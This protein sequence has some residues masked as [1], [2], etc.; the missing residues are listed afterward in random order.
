MF[1]RGPYMSNLLKSLVLPEVEKELGLQVMAQKIRLNLLPFYVEALE[2][3]VFDESGEKIIAAASIKAYMSIF[4][5]LERRLIPT[6]IVIKKPKVWLDR[7]KAAALIGSVGGPENKEAKAAELNLK[8]IVVREGE[9]YYRDEGLKGTFEARGLNAEVILRDRP[10]VVMSVG[11]L[12]AAV[13]DWPEMKGSL[14]ANFFV[15]KEGVEIK[16]I[17]VDMR[18]STLSGS[19]DYF[20]N[21][22]GVLRLDINVL[23]ETIKELRRLNKPGYG[24]IRARGTLTLTEDLH[25][26]LLDFSVKGDF[27]LQTLLEA[28]KA[29]TSHELTGLVSFDGDLFGSV[30]ELKGRADARLRDGNLYTIDVD[31]IRCKVSY[32]DRWLR[33]SEGKAELY[34]G[35]GEL[36]VSFLLPRAKP[37]TVEADFR[38]VDSRSAFGKIGLGWMNLPAGKVRG[39]L[40][41]SGMEFAPEGWASYESGGRREDPIGRVSTITGK[42]RMKNHVVTLVDME[43]TSAA[44]RLT[45]GG[46]LNTASHIIDLEGDLYTDDVMELTTPYFDKLRG[47]AEFHGGVSGRTGDPMVEG[48]FLIHDSAL[49]DYPLGEVAAEASYRKNLLRVERANAESGESVYK[50]A[51]TVKFPEATG[52]L[53]LSKPDFDLEL[54]VRKADLGDILGMLD[55]EIPIE[56]DID[57]KVNIKGIGR[58][59]YSGDVEIADGMVWD[60]PLSSASLSFS[61]DYKAA[62]IRNAELRSGKSMLLLDGRVAEGGEFSF[63]AS[64]KGLYLKDALPRPLPLNYRVALNAE[65]SGTFDNPKIDLSSTLS[66]GT[67]GEWPVGGG[68]VDATLTGKDLA[69]DAKLLDDKASAKGG[70]SIAGDMPW[71]AEVEVEGARLDFLATKFLKEIPEDLLLSITGRASMSGTK[72]HVSANVAVRQVTMAM[73]GQSFTNDSDILFTADDTFIKFPDFKL[74]SGTT[75]VSFQGE[76]RYGDYYDIMVYGASSL[77][78]LK[79]FSD[80]I[81]L[82]R[83]NANYVLAVQGPWQKPNVNGGIDIKGG[84]FGIQGIPQRLAEVNGYSYFEDDVVVIDNLEAKLGGGDIEVKGVMT[85]EGLSPKSVNLDMLLD[86]VNVT[87]TTGLKA[88][89]GGSIIF[90][91]LPAERLLTGEITINRAEYKDRI[92][93]KSWLLKVRQTEA[94][95]IARKGPFDEVKLSLKLYG[96]EDIVIDNNLATAEL[97]MDL[98]LRGTVGQPLLL[99]RIE[100]NE[101]K[102]YFRNSVFR[103]AHATAD[104]SDSIYTDPYVDIVSETTVKGYHVWLTLEGKLDHLDMTLLSDPELED[105]EILSLLTVG[106]FGESLRGLEGSIGAAEASS[107]IA[108]K[109]QDLVEERFR[110]LTGVTRFTIEPYVSRKTGAITPRVSVSKGL[111][112]EDLYVTYSSSIST[113]EEQEIVLEYVINRNV[114][115][116]GGQDDLGTLGGDIKFR[117]LFK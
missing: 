3:K 71:N 31:D 79:A 40:Y 106:E 86:D 44:S 97:E 12:S 51:G 64:S 72:N 53:D 63:K 95:G 19:G 114:S 6:V 94:L 24:S 18:G 61:Y 10:E 84:A 107:V 26:P 22:T 102:V 104:Y 73:F 7:T 32:E 69:F 65:G 35:T 100:S 39:R 2:I 113:S 5:V 4:D 101:G 52:L 76:F 88:N 67:F 30:S 13:G 11:E 33:F 103:L 46:S 78:P 98:L 54:H 14:E 105:E 21:R 112:R 108:G 56:G 109:F 58:P 90:R 117:F 9:V 20:F 41:T 66:E 16:Q 81:T 23:A 74:R 15:D 111:A 50:G 48:R 45:F 28:V 96:D 55:I 70:I 80:R 1:L 42:Y 59:T 27:F 99:G 17:D 34:N 91:G 57:G 75:S 110:E 49:K 93:Y 87:I 116:Q 47:G 89:I 37:Y 85:L 60:V 83:G 43:A 77:A 92:E 62:I 68:K 25:N 8:N 38:D 29:R 36:N 82:L 115:L